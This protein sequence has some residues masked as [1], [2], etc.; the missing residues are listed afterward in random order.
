MKSFALPFAVL[1]LGG[2]VSA[3]ER[4]ITDDEGRIVTV[5][6]ATPEH[7]RNAWPEEWEQEFLTRRSEFI[8]QYL[9]KAGV[10]TALENEKQG[11]PPS[12]LAFCA[13]DRK[14][15]LAALQTGD[16]MAGNHEHTEGIDYYW[17]FTLKGQMRKYFFL[18]QYLDPPYFER[19]TTGAQA[20]TATDP[21][22]NTELVLLTGSADEDVAAY[23]NEA[24]GKIWRDEAGLEELAAAAMAEYE[25]N[26]KAHQAGL[27]KK[28]AEFVRA[29][30]QGLGAKMPET[31]DEW[32]A[33]WELLC[34][35]DWMIYEEYDRRTN[36]RPHPQFGIGTGPVGTDWSPKTRGGVVDWRNTDNLRGMREVSVYLMAEATGS[37][38]VRKVFKERIRSTARNFLTVGNGEWDSPAY[39]SHT[40]SAYV[41]LYDFAQD[42]EVR[43]L[44]KAIL[45]FV[46]TSAAIKFYEDSFGGPNCRDYGT[47]EGLAGPGSM[48]HFWCG[49]GTTHPENDIAHYATSAYRPP[50]A[51]VA[52]ARKEFD[53]PVELF[54]TH[55]HYQNFIPSNRDEPKY[56]ETTWIANTYQMGSL[57]EGGQYDVNGC[58]ILV[59]NDG[60]GTDFFIPSSQR[61][62]NVCVNRSRTDRFAQYRNLLL[63]LHKPRKGQGVFN[64]LVPE[65]AQ[66]EQEGGVT[67]LRFARTWAA[68]RGI[69][70]AF[71]G[72]DPKRAGK[73]K[74]KGEPMPG[75]ILAGD[76]TGEGLCGYVIEFGEAETH[77]DYDA[78]KAAVLAEGNLDV[79]E[80]A[81]GKATYTGALGGRVGLQ[82]NDDRLTVFR[83]GEEHPRDAHRALWKPADGGDAPVSLGWKEGHLHVEAGGHVFDGRFDV[84]SGTYSFEGE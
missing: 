12:I 50:A 60:G 15:A 24:M 64:F 9:G 38:L 4:V 41:N 70:A 51:V 65:G 43:L 83:D 11:Y 82:W 48:I 71:A 17:C 79:S 45:D 25:Q 28:F 63:C 14:E 6:V 68:V 75:P 58:K 36:L 1:L 54:A 39:L 62:G 22:P 21:R 27:K 55:P 31:P 67:F 16:V 80:F 18:G 40:A 33:W 61:K 72:L 84:E 81:A 66:V 52:L 26:P 5:P 49:E 2:I 47:V 3:E 7:L 59:E 30:K 73:F 44:A 10:N 34:T 69:E 56:H 53:R 23:A 32:L 29:N 8:R 74:R 35:G 20:W 77:G 57:L 78:F 76:A 46:H 37:E 42:E 19:M 13:G